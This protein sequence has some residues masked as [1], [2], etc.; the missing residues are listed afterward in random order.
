MKA[1]TINEHEQSR[2]Y[3]GNFDEGGPA[4]NGTVLTKPLQKYQYHNHNRNHKNSTIVYHR[5]PSI[6]SALTPFIAFELDVEL[7]LLP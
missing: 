7:I 4:N 5:G 6:T 3:F 1:Q 2:G